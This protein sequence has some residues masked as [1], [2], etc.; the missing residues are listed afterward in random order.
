[1]FKAMRVCAIIAVAAITTG[2]VSAQT[3]GFG[4]GQQGSQNYQANAELAKFVSAHGGHEVRV[5][6]YGGSGSYMPL[7]DQ[8]KLDLAAI[9]GNELHEAMAGRGAFKR[10][11]L[12]NLG[13]IAT[14]FPMQVGIFV[15]K[16]AP[17]KS[18]KDLKGRRITYGLTSQP[19]LVGDID[20]IL[21]TGGLTIG[22]LKPVMVPSVGRGVDDFIAGRVD[23][24]YFA[25][26]G[27]KLIEADASVGG[28]RFLPIERTPEAEA[29]TKKHAPASYIRTESP[30]EGK[31]GIAG[32]TPTLAYDYLFVAGAH[33]NE[34][35]VYQLTKLLAERSE[36]LTQTSRMYGGFTPETMAKYR[37]QF[38]Y[39][40][41]AV[42]YYTE[43]GMWPPK[44]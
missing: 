43:K 6:S 33:V 17:F 30:G 11:E 9:A 44:G 31:V 27:G 16:D 35:V 36:L 1:M 2:G 21:A 23:A 4:A 37:G 19:S 24:A 42:R 29:A 20:G 25:L 15:K 38:Q 41:G 14:L 34:E 39:H 26:R 22:D 28:I 5:E 10:H 13:V 32:P 3:L 40:P 18:I 8:G 7:M 12:R